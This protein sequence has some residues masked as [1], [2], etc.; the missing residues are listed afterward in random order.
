MRQTA[1]LLM[2]AD[3]SG[4][5]RFVNFHATSMLHAEEIIT[6]LLESVIDGMEYPLTIAKLEGDAVFMYAEVPAGEELPAAASINTQIARMFAGFS[7]RAQALIDS[8]HGC[9]CDACLSIGL[10]RLKMVIHY[11]QVAIK[12]IRQFT[13]IG[14][15]EVVLLHRLLKNSVPSKEYILMTRAAH[16]LIGN[17]DGQNGE[18]RVETIDDFDRQQVVVFYPQPAP[19][20]AHNTEAVSGTSLALDLNKHAMA[21][22]F[23]RKEAV[24]FQ[25]IPGERVNVAQYL[26][27]VFISRLVLLR[28]RLLGRA[29]RWAQRT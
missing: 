24:Q 9:I 27:E 16:K 13:E 15:R 5:T 26:F 18:Q 2:I 12:Q 6:E 28:D 4:Y 14:G 22:L 11:G 25:H 1:A 19:A 29:G 3:I 21:R 23:G 8:R 17:F 7:A 20:H 10:L